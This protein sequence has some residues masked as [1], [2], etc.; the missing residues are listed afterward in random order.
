MWRIK[1]IMKKRRIAL[2][3][4]ALV[5]SGSDLTWAQELVSSSE[6][7][8]MSSTSTTIATAE[9]SETPPESMSEETV[10]SSET[11]V[12]EATLAPITDS[13]KISGTVD[14]S[15]LA[16]GQ[17]SLL[18][19]ADNADEVQSIQVAIW[20]DPSQKNMSWY[21]AS[22]QGDGT[23]L[24][25][26]DYKNHE[27]L[28]GNYQIQAYTTIDNKE[29]VTNLPAVMIEQPNNANA[30]FSAEQL[31][32]D[33]YRLSLALQNP[34]VKGVV[35]PTW[36]EFSGQDD[37]YRYTARYDTATKLWYADV[38]IANH[39]D[40]G[41][42]ITHST[43]V[44]ANSL[45]HLRED[46]YTFPELKIESAR[47]EQADE[48]SG[49]FQIR[50]ITNHPELVSKVEI[51]VWS[52]EN[53][54][55]DLRWYQGVKQADG[56]YTAE[57]NYKDHQYYVGKY[58]IHAY[59]WAVNGQ[60]SN[61]TVAEDFQ[62]KEPSLDGELTI[63][64]SQTDPTKYIASVKLA[65]SVDAVQFPTWTEVGGQDD[66]CWYNGSYDEDTET[67]QAEIDLKNHPEGGEMQTHVW[68]TRNGE[69]KFITHQA[70][71]I[72]GVSMTNHSIDLG[73]ASKGKFK[74]TVTV[75]D[76]DNVKSLHLPIWSDKNGQDDI[77]WYEA[78]KQADGTFTAEVDYKNHNFDTGRYFIH[79]YIESINGITKSFV[80]D[81]NLIL[82]EFTLESTGIE[83]TPVDEVE[84]IYRLSIQVENNERV[85][86]VQF[87]IWTE[88]NGQ[89]DIYW[90][91][92]TCNSTNSY[93]SVDV[94]LSDNHFDGTKLDVQAYATIEGLGLY[95]M[96]NT[97]FKVLESC[98]PQLVN[99]RGNHQ[100]TPENSIPAFENAS[101]YA[102]ET[103]IQLTSDNRWVIMHDRTID[104]MTNGSGRVSKMSFE[105]LRS[106]RIDT[107]FGLSNYSSGELVV[108]TLE[109]YLATCQKQGVIPVIEIKTKKISEANYNNLVEIVNSYDFDGNVKFISFYLKPLQTMKQKMPQI[110]TMYLTGSIS[111]KTI[112]QAKSLGD[113][114][115]LNVLWTS[116]TA[117]SITKA[118]ENN[119]IVGAWTVPGSQIEAM[120]N[121]GV[122]FITTND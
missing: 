11:T 103:D 18:I 45:I 6:T 90:Y 39:P 82:P 91:D 66:I 104:R 117:E 96:G 83:V 60:S 79:A 99:H 72:D 71:S 34:N 48:V 95:G 15:N 32:S 40:A 87:P 16:N 92:A 105:E 37:I 88:L 2:L 61:V 111:D 98:I 109:E 63:A 110:S 26:F 80:V 113:N 27:Y 84:G 5:V 46:S 19:R 10:E 44:T 51:P 114:S 68:A 120:C 29:I 21:H 107:G 31:N 25:S 55:D 28:T 76:P 49:K 13:N 102:A 53:G 93:W 118:K 30:A 69:M 100:N 41:K 94:K 75:D 115:G 14:Q 108:P 112:D 101:H 8:M 77:V 121:L 81:N 42:M 86:G 12:E 73:Q 78:S 57:V 47:V 36:S 4:V 43:I 62:L 106:Y 97:S 20:S 35:F 85:N 89:D 7:V 64:P 1:I 56:S 24:V 54:Q 59:V 38:P 9:S 116:I 17:F 67:W 50:V 119:L 3:I 74:V 58:H 23:Y 52:E 70:Y 65:S 33:T 22:R 122:D